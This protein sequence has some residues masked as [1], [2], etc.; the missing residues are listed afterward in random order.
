MNLTTS[1]IDI[2]PTYRNSDK[3]VKFGD[4]VIIKRGNL[5]NEGTL[6]SIK[7]DL[8]GSENYFNPIKF[9]ICACIITEDGN[10]ATLY[11]PEFYIAEVDE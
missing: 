10:I 8:R 7:F 4:H 1:F 3:T 6:E 9:H 2:W 5:E 11:D